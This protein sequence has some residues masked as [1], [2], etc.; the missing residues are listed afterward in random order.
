MV[1]KTQLSESE[2][3][4]VSLALMYRKSATK[5]I[6]MVAF[7]FLLIAIGGFVASPGQ[8]NKLSLIVP[9][10]ML[11]ALPLSVYFGSKKA[12]QT[13]MQLRETVLFEIDKDKLLVS[14]ETYSIA[15]QWNMIYKVTQL[16]NW[17]FIW[18]DKQR[19]L[20]IA[21]KDVWGGQIAELKDI[22]DSHGVPNN[23]KYL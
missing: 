23:L 13:N 19:I 3:I 5:T 11:T 6:A 12:Y 17:I 22:L 15:Y 1:I 4:N 8:A 20:P 2:F 21:A 18:Q 16:K 14:G 9:L 7:I 10:A